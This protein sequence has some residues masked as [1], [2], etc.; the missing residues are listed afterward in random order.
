MIRNYFKTALRN[1][2]K[3]KIFSLINVL[4]L[5]VGLAGSMLIAR[6]VMHELSYDQDQ[7]RKERIF[8]VHL[9]RYNKGQLETQWA[10]GAAA[11][12]PD[13]KA[14]F[15]EVQYY[16]RMH[17]DKET[18]SHNDVTFKEE[19]VYFASE[20]F[21][22]V[23]SYPLIQGIDSVVLRAPHSIVI[24]KTFAK[25]YFGDQDPIGKNLKKNGREDWTVTGVF[26]DLPVNTHMKVDAL[27]SFST[28][29][30]YMRSP[31]DLNTYQWDGF[32]T[33]VQLR[34]NA[35]VSTL[36]SKLPAFVESKVGEDLKKYNAGMVFK[37]EPITRIHLYASN[38]MMDFGPNGNGKSVYF[39]GIIAVFILVI[40][41]INYINL[42]TARSMERAREVG[43]RKV[44]GSFKSQLIWQF[45]L[46]SFIINLTAFLVAV[47][48]VLILLPSFSNLS[49]TNINAS[50]FTDSVFIGGTIAVFILGVI[51]SGI[52][53]AFVLSGFKPVTVLKGK[54]QTSAQG[55][56]LR[57]GLVIFQF[58]ASITL[59]VGTFTVYRQLDFMRTADQG[60]NI[61]QTIVV[62]GPGIHDSTYVNRFKAFQSDMISYPEVV[63]VTA[64]TSIPGRQPD[65]NAG[66]I[67]K[68][69]EPDDM[70]NQYR[71]LGVDESFVPTF[72]LKI[73]AGRNFSQEMKTDRSAVLFNESAIRQIGYKTPEEAIDQEIYFWGDTFRIV[74]VLK[75]YR[76]ESMKRNFEPLIFRNIDDARSFYSIR[77]KSNEMKSFV[78]LA[79]EKFKASF[80]GNPFL[81]FFMD[82]YYNQQYQS[83][84]QFGKVFGIFA[85]LAIFIACMG[86]FGLSSYTVVQRTKEI[87]VRKVLGA[88]VPQII[89]LLFKDFAVLVAVAILISVPIAWIVMSNWLNEFATRITLS[90]W[91]FVIPG[92]IVMGIAWLTISLHTFKA[93]SAN[94]V[95][96]LRYE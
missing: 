95:E 24:S 67:R 13:L 80:P 16:V 92:L 30:G 40:A 2:L 3:N 28:F 93:A 70:G 29:I 23:F 71:V 20:D 91:L 11:I 63:G 64:S 33:Y 51:F 72:E 66:G 25:K 37:L 32:M 78:T 89:Q 52:Y 55:S 68:V 59:I 65:W 46:E 76:Q 26:E 53:P 86:L 22:R 77:V 49:G 38:L 83:D 42:S 50:F 17:E 85:T 8:R 94:P 15:Q 10:A 48:G 58:A 7:V 75:D 88:T 73:V 12:G 61:D 87:G 62:R 39:L 27:L 45:M 79:E 5:A 81:F 90:W 57:K 21:F 60:V 74:G 14:N 44:M 35:N 4:G 56:Y 84:I 82:D 36:Q 41:W 47:L 1:I 18:F 54:M 96:S 19:N 43:V 6:Y 69:G 31:D 9:D 34:P